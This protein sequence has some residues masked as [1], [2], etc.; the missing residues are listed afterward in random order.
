MGHAARQSNLSDGYST[1]LTGIE[2]DKCRAIGCGVI[3]I[4]HYPPV[5]LITASGLCYEDGFV[6]FA[7]STKVV[8]GDSARLEVIPGKPAPPASS[9]SPM[10]P[11]LALG[12]RALQPAGSMGAVALRPKLGKSLRP[13]SEGTT[14][15]SAISA[16]TVLARASPAQPATNVTINLPASAART[17]PKSSCSPKRVTAARR[18]PR[19]PGPA[20]GPRQRGPDE[21]V[22]RSI[23]RLARRSCGAARCPMIW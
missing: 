18:Q 7:T 22:L 20:S 6:N 8:G 13:D 19:S 1:E 5:A 15:A 2:D 12:W 23:N 16:G 10:R 9:I 17:G 21:V 11:R 3:D 14:A 4:S